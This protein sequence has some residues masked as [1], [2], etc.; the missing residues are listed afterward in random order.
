MPPF[1]IPSLNEWQIAAG[2][3]YIDPNFAFKDEELFDSDGKYLANFGRIVDENNYMVKDYPEKGTHQNNFTSSVKSFPANDYQ[4]YDMAGN[5]AEWTSSNVI[6]FT[7]F[8]DYNPNTTCINDSLHTYKY[9][10]GGSWADGPIYLRW[11]TNTLVDIRK[12]SSRVGF[13]VSMQFD[14]DFN[15]T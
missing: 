13:R 4:L 10:K 1:G 7:N 12:S 8:E 3:N 15:K 14:F 9:V 6:F 5:V 11:R 2:A